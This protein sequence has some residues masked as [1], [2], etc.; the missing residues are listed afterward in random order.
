MKKLILPLLAFALIGN[1][2]FAQDEEVSLDTFEQCNNWARHYCQTG[3][4]EQA[5]NRELQRLKK[6]GVAITL[7][8]IK[9]SAMRIKPNTPAPAPK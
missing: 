1:S 4:H 3:L 5:V 9:A 6:K 2:A 8:R 7:E